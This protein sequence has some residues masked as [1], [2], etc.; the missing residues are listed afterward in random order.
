MVILSYL[1]F[2]VELRQIQVD[3]LAFYEPLHDR[4]I[5]L[6]P[7]SLF[8]IQSTICHEAFFENSRINAWKPSTIFA[9][10]LNFCF[11]WTKD[12]STRLNKFFLL[13]LLLKNLANPPGSLMS[14]LFRYTVY[15]N[16]AAFFLHFLC[17]FR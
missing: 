1:Y 8:R 3:L 7:R 9:K 10:K 11:S 6:V 13:E 16:L 4:W 15:K 14:G 17:F 12:I 5:Y 2:L